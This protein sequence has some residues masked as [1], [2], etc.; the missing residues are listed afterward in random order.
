MTLVHVVYF[1]RKL[2]Q[3]LQYVRHNANQHAMQ[4][5]NRPMP[6]HV[7][8]MPQFFNRIVWTLT[9]KSYLIW[10]Q[11][12]WI[13]TT[14]DAVTSIRKLHLHWMKGAHIYNT[15][16]GPW[17]NHSPTIAVLFIKKSYWTIGLGYLSTLQIV[18]TIYLSTALDQAS[19]MTSTHFMLIH[20]FL[21][22][23]MSIFVSI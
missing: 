11:Q 1:K 15:S 22:T 9:C 10:V 17:Y 2:Y 18:P 4:A 16:L 3:S 21:S 5:H 6:I 13:A 23:L 12:N 20:I 8:M 7:Y 14:V 19:L